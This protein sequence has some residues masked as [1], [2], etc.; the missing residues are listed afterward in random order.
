MQFSEISVRSPA[1][2]IRRTD[3][4]FLQ[5][6]SERVRFLDIDRFHFKSIGFDSDILQRAFDRFVAAKTCSAYTPSL[7]TKHSAGVAVQ[8]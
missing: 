1:L 7:C 8:V 3:N 6:T 5:S 2:D 4:W